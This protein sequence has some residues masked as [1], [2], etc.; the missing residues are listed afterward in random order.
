MRVDIANS[1][2]ISQ[3]LPTGCD[4]HVKLGEN[5]SHLLF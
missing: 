3:Q 2:S 4:L 5:Y 1:S